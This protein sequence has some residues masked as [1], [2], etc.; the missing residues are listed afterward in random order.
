MSIEK[1]D[2]YNKIQTF[3]LEKKKFK[4]IWINYHNKNE[5]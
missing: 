2:F 5:K 1:I 3:Y 4:Y